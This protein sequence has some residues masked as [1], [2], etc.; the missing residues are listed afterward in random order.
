MEAWEDEGADTALMQQK[1]LTAEKQGVCLMFICIFSRW[2]DITLAEYYSNA[3]FAKIL[4]ALST[5]LCS[6]SQ[7]F[8]LMYSVRSDF[9]FHR[10]ASL[11]SKEVEAS[12][13]SPRE[14]G[15]RESPKAAG[16]LWRAYRLCDLER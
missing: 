6:N 15:A 11:A 8:L 7:S 5:E 13:E 2:R 1:L 16:D 4:S 12:R 9:F 10:A 14:S 3:D